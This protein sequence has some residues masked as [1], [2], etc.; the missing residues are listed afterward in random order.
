M[1]L[2][3][4]RDSWLVLGLLTL[5]LLVT[6]AAA[7]Q[8]TRSA[9]L[10]ALTSFSSAPDGARALWLWLDELDYEVNQEAVSFFEPP[11]DTSLIF[12]L[13]PGMEVTAEE[14]QVPDEWVEDGGTLV[15]AG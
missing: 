14:W 1:K 11:P 9:K 13:E 10:P 15:L 2:S 12:L 4:S 5:L 7:I 6:V 3:L 8:Q